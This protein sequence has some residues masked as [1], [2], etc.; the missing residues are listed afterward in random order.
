MTPLGSS[1]SELELDGFFRFVVGPVGETCNE[2]E[3]GFVDGSCGRLLKEA[4][5][6]SVCRVR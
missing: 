3:R 4:P 2:I 6:E 1:S 5:S